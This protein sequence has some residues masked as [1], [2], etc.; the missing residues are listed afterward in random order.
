M[1]SK[2]AKIQKNIHLIILSLLGLLIAIFIGYYFIGGSFVPENFTRARQDSALIA[3]DIVSLTEESIG[4]LEKILKAD[5]R[6]EFNSAIFMVKEELERVKNAQLKAVELTNKLDTMAK[7]TAGITPKKA[8]D[9]AIVAIS[10]ELSLISHLIVYNSILNGLLQTLELK[11]SG[12]IGYDAKEVQT[13][14][15]NMNSE[16][17]EINNLNN[18]FNDKMGEF[19]GLIK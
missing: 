17:G 13:L 10:N 4:N 5:S 1:V 12:D 18:L 3:K 9:L 7:A 2:S 8:R 15:K 6:Y 19:D 14:V 16:A 11:F